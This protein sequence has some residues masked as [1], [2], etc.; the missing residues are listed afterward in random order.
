MNT[1]PADSA[2]SGV[3]GFRTA[4]FG[5]F[6]NDVEGFQSNF[7]P[8][9]LISS[10][11]FASS[12]SRLAAYSSGVLASGSVPSAT[13]RLRMSSDEIILRSSA[14][15]RR[16]CGGGARPAAP[17]VPHHGPAG[18]PAGR[19]PA[20]AG[21]L[22]WPVRRAGGVAGGGRSL[23]ASMLPIVAGIVLKPSG[24]WPPSRSLV[25]GPV[26]L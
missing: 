24:T 3:H 12:R 4:A 13:R 21:P 9:F 22:G 18:E 1:D 25:S 6:R 10:A 17:A 2:P 15:T 14:L 16:L 7:S 20:G 5:G 8:S 19:A 26:P 11:H 23:P